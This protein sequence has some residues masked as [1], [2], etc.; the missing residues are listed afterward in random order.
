LF[1]I[2]KQNR[3]EKTMPGEKKFEPKLI[4]NLNIDDLVLE[5]DFYKKLNKLF[6]IYLGFNK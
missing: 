3:L 5:D 4:Y 2:N 1:P 6:K